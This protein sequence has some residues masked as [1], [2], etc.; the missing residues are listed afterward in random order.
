MALTVQDI[1]DKTFTAVRLRE[2]YDQNEVD[3][4]LDQI[5]ADYEAALRRAEDAAI[6]STTEMRKI[7]SQNFLPPI[8]IEPPPESPTQASVRILELAQRT[9]DDVVSD[10]HVQADRIMAAARA[11]AQQA[12]AQLAQEAEA[13]IRAARD[14]QLAA[15]GE[16]EANRN[17]LE[18]RVGELAAM[19]Q[20][21]REAVQ[22]LSEFVANNPPIK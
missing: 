8:P 9:A 7:E 18:G 13:E 12:N 20:K 22:R 15:I 1:K 17:K 14:R 11:E 10:A 6:R 3:D 4:F 16:L 2:G 21:Y 5:A 19:E